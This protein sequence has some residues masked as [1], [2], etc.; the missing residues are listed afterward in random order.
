MELPAAAAL[1]HAALE[2]AVV[3]VVRRTLY[4]QVVHALQRSVVHPEKQL[5]RVNRG[6][7]TKSDR[8]NLSDN[9]QEGRVRSF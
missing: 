1:L 7:V 9:G 3:P 6:S 8:V 2:L 4:L 5:R